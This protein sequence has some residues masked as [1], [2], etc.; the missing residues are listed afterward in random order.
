M[1]QKGFA[2][3][4]LLILIGIIAVAYFSFS[5]SKKSS[6]E[7]PS[8]NST[9]S[10]QAN[11]PSK[12]YSVKIDLKSEDSTPPIRDYPD[13]KYT[14]SEYIEK[15]L[16][17]P[18]KSISNLLYDTSHGSPYDRS[19]FGKK[20]YIILNQPTTL[21]PSYGDQFVTM[22]IERIDDSL[23]PFLIKNDYCEQDSD[24]SISNAGC[25]VGA[26]N[27]YH[28]YIDPPWG[29]G[30]AGYKGAYSTF[31]YGEY[32]NELDCNLDSIEFSGSKCQNHVCTETGAKKICA[33]E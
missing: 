12:L 13:A 30:P 27:N 8:P 15:L 26:F 24:C 2:L 16:G 22:A 11:S 33:Q 21:D 32:D 1:R 3:P 23:L 28:T 25:T 18:S 4:I 29:C 7:T 20:Y 31:E 5:L 17:L 14:L 9:M 10:A 6:Y 19:V